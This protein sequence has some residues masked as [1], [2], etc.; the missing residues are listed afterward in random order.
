MVALLADGLTAR[1]HEVVLVVPAS[2]RRAAGDAR[3]AAAHVH[4]LPSV[5][6]RPSIDLRLAATWPER[7]RIVLGRARVDL[8]HSH[9]EGPVGWS[10]RAAARSLGLPLVHTLH[11]F[12]GHYLHYLGVPRPLR[13]TA[14]SGLDRV[15]G[16]FLRPYDLVVAPSP[17]AVTELERLAPTV[18]RVHVPNGVRVP[19]PV[20]DPAALA[21]V[22]RRV[23]GRN[24]SHR[25]L[26]VG[27][28]AP[29]KR[30]REL[31]D[32]FAP[33]LATRADLQLV[34]VG[35][36]P[37]L[38][39]VRRHVRSLGLADRVHLPGALPPSSVHALQREVTVAVSASL[40]ENHPWRC[41]RPRRRAGH[42]RAGP[43]T[44]SPGWSWTGSTGSSGPATTSSPG[45]PSPCSNDPTD[46]PPTARRRSGSPAGTRWTS[47]STRSQPRT[48]ACSTSGRDHRRGG[49]PSGPRDPG[50]SRPGRP[51]TTGWTTRGRWR[52]TA[53]VSADTAS[54]EARW[55]GGVG[56]A[57]RPRPSRRP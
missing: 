41:S 26:V 50:R 38:A 28:I 5:P 20:P 15:L 14:A 40:S 35:G 9:T 39:P 33:H 43:T 54:T 2:G 8:V 46:S 30:V 45:G 7:L 47:T 3:P 24:V 34:L 37:L 23:P 21:A 18:P 48:P 49:R 1:G 12:Y 32:A 57:G 11:T 29:E 6:W 16:R 25:L 10:A 55:D 4:A 19:P 27:R 36:G 22:Q 52:P 51:R 44:T 17:R 53:T 42:W 13:G 56:A 31:V